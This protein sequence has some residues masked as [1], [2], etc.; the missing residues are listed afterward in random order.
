MTRIVGAPS[1][2]AALGEWELRRFDQ[3]IQ[4]LENLLEALAARFGAGLLDA[5]L[6][7]AERGFNLPL[8]RAAP[9]AAT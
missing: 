4:K 9:S 8:C 7:V 5:D 3:L 1:G 6:E 2:A